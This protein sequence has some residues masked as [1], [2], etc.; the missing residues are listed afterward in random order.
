[1]K[2]NLL[3]YDILHYHPEALELL[4]KNFKVTTLKDPG[5]DSDFVLKN[6]EILMAP[7]GFQVDKQKIDRCPNLKVIASSTLSIP[8]I[9]TVY[10]GSK[11]I[12]TIYLGNE[13]AFLETITPTAELTIGLIIAITRH[14]P[15]SYKAALDSKWGGRPF[16]RR[17]PKMLSKMSLGIIGLGR[18]GRMVASYGTAFGMKVY[19]YSPRSK[20][21]AYEYCDS[22]AELAKSS[23]VV[24]LHAHHSQE[25]EGM[26]DKNFFHSMKRG[27]YFVNTARG[28]L[29]DEG[30]LLGALES[31]HLGGAALD[32]LADEYDLNFRKKLNHHPMVEYARANENLILTPHYAGATSDAWIKTQTKTVELVMD[33]L[34]PSLL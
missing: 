11:G 30:A 13:A 20:E 12:E 6:T 27:A 29:V 31:G 10:A 9:D 7:L 32:V 2:L 18:L 14:L 25:T 26:I 1:M 28:A 5:F 22:L 33:A 34:K 15:W 4:Q 8:H 3:Y 16:G 21:P 17:T 23:D 24:S 19:Y